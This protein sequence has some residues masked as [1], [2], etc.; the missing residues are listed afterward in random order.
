MPKSRTAFW[1][2]KFVAN[3]ARDENNLKALSDL[4]WRTMVVWECETW[5]QKKLSKR[6]FWFL[7][8]SKKRA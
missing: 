4:G 3:V 1:K 5:D 6:L 7:T 8:K 2:E